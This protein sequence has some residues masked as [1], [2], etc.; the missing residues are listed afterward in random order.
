MTRV[1]SL[2]TDR[3]DSEMIG[4]LL[5]ISLIAVAVAIVFL[6]LI[7]QPISGKIPEITPNIT[8]YTSTPGQTYIRITHVGGDPLGESSSTVWNSDGTVDPSEIRL[9]RSDGSEVPWKGDT[10]AVGT[11]LLVPAGSA[12]PG[13]VGV[14]YWDSSGQH[15]LFRQGAGMEPGNALQASFTYS[16]KPVI[17]GQVIQ[18]TDITTGGPTSW[19]WSFGDGG[20]SNLK[21]PT[22]TYLSAGTYTVL[23]TASNAEGMD[24]VSQTIVVYSVPPHLQVSFTGVPDSGMAPLSVQFTDTSS[25]TPT[26]WYWDFG[27]GS[28]SSLQNPLHSFQNS[29][30]YQVKLTAANAFGSGAATQTITV[31]VCPHPQ[32]SF[33]AAPMSGNAPLTVQ[34]T[35]ASTGS[36]TS[37]LWDFGDGGTG[38]TRNA[39]HIFS[40]QGSFVVSLTVSNSCGQATASQ[41]I[42]VTSCPVPYATFTADKNSGPVPLAV[43]FT[44]TSTGS[45]TAWSWNFGDGATSTI[46]NPSHTYSGAGTYSVTL[47][48]SSACGSSTSDSIVV[49]PCQA[50][51]ASFDV[52]KNTGPIPLMVYFSDTSTGSPTAWSWNFGN[53]DTSTTRNPVYTYGSPGI[54]NVTL[55]ASN[56]CGSS[57]SQVQVIT[58]CQAPAASFTVDR[59]SGNAPLTVQFTDTSTGSPTSWSWNFG[60]GG[61]STTQNPSYTYTTAGTWTATL[62]AS[63]SC[64]SSVSQSRTITVNACPTPVA[65]FTV[66][67]SSGNA[68]LTVQF[69]DT[70]TGSPTA[71]SWT[72]G[73]GGSS[74]AQNPLYTYNEPGTFTANLMATNNCGASSSS[75]VITVSPQT[76]SISGIKYDDM[77][78][79]EVRDP[80]EGTL[81]NWQ[82]SLYLASGGSALQSTMTDN[83]GAYIFSGLTIPGT[84][85]VVETLQSGWSPINP[86]TG[87]ISTIFLTKASPN[88]AGQNFGNALNKPKC[89]FINGRVTDSSGNGVGGRAVV[90]ADKQCNIILSTTTDNN[91]YFSIGVVGN[92]HEYTLILTDIQGWTT[93]S[94]TQIFSH[95]GYK[96]KGY[97]DLKFTGPCDMS[98]T[99]YFLV[100]QG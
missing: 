30:T 3:A 31:A 81:K 47:T 39:T 28:T 22:H 19:S 66:D 5:L 40:N 34:F 29:G 83:N 84:Y 77:N 87:E 6:V 60:D 18:F 59:S 85:R 44:D 46:R 57:V 74:T 96:G 63:N 20:T 42:T 82:M 21:N 51:A 69:T 53:G 79:N 25:G 67:K 26:S 2:K 10:W 86:L 88:V 36:P 99:R 41:T 9:I 45:P 27:D 35:D 65:S 52:D 91:G 98:F 48:V 90:A 13:T 50:P 49:T 95:C 78:K 7:S 15:L 12:D 8:T 33:L 1:R 71:W 68:P 89:N 75:R 70:S 55:T 94:P 4:S 37:W 93:I 61:T 56:S 11:A 58:P 100:K 72:F 76:G 17:A 23:L 32:A 97:P 38:V 73:D 64:G 43:Q 62:T 80:G 14:V 54:Y 24:S 92:G 16:P